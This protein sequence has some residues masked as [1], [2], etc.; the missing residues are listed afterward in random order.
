MDGDGLTAL[1]IAIRGCDGDED[2]EDTAVEM[3]RVI[4]D[5]GADINK[6]DSGGLSP[7]GRAASL[8]N[9]LLFA[10][11]LERGARYSDNLWEMENISVDI[12]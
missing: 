6:E 3:L 12:L 2:V 8:D 7:L 11:L 1:E 4:I 5:A 9:S 10:Y